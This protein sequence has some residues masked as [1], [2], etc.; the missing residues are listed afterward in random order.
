MSHLRDAFVA[1]FGTQLRVGIGLFILGIF[2]F[3]TGQD[4]VAQYESGSGQIAR[5]FSEQDQDAYRNAQILRVLGPAISV[6]GAALVFRDYTNQSHWIW[7]RVS[8]KETGGRQTELS[9]Y[10]HTNLA[11]GS[12]TRYD[13]D[14]DQS[15]VLE[16]SVDALSDSDINVILTTADRAEEF[17]ESFGI[18]HKPEGSAFGTTTVE[19]KTRIPSGNWALLI[20]NTGRSKH[21]ETPTVVDIEVE[22]ALYQ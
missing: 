7:S 21:T 14:V 6:I 20:D 1:I 2:L 17:E 3:I 9:N 22:Y 5:T 11:P 19:N 18:D 8:T 15:S 13:I 12:Y 16:Y 10:D 4:A